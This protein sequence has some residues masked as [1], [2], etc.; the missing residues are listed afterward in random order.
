M[1]QST[2]ILSPLRQW[3]ELIRIKKCRTTT[4]RPAIPVTSEVRRHASLHDLPI[5]LPYL[6]DQ[7][8]AGSRHAADTVLY[9]GYGS[10]LSAETFQG[11]RN[12]TPLSQINVVVP[13]LSLNFDLPGIPYS[14]PCFANTGYRD[15]PTHGDVE[16]QAGAEDYHKD[17]WFKGLVG[18]VYEVTKEDLVHIIATEGGGSGYK[19]VLVDCFA[20]S[21]DPLEEI[22][23]SP[24]GAPFRAHTLLAPSTVSHPHHSYAQPSPRYLKLM[25]DGAAEHGLPYEYQEFL[26]QIRTYHMTTVKQRLGQ[27]IFLSLWSPLLMLVIGGGAAMFLRP[28]GTYPGWFARLIRAM[29]TAVWASYDPLFK[30]TFGDGERTIGD[31]SA[32]DGRPDDEKTPLIPSESTGGRG[33]GDSANLV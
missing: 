11:K 17:R 23:F 3:N 4:P 12:I 6:S 14:E 31:K 28:D 10:N 15:V 25:I 32:E 24:S 22:P 19:D 26:Q 5:E 7:S 8:L 27:V 29:F 20:L 9:L 33:P 16:S 30:V 18:V 2:N 13:I 21:G 1:E